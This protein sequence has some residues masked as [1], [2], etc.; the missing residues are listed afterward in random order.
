MQGP[1]KSAGLCYLWAMRSH[2][3]M[4]P[5]H[6]WGICKRIVAVIGRSWSSLVLLHRSELCGLDMLD[7]L[8]V[9][10]DLICLPPEL[11]APAKRLADESYII[12]HIQY[13]HDQTIGSKTWSRIVLCS[14]QRGRCDDELVFPAIVIK[15][16]GFGIYGDF[17]S[18]CHF[19]SS[20]FVVMSLLTFLYRTA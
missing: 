13:L 6:Q 19:V 7:N 2:G 3:A 14:P 18:H 1:R 11:L 5:P 12:L 4:I 8:S 9:G 16:T 20:L 15:S 17:S 10:A